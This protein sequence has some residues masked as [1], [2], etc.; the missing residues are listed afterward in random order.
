MSITYLSLS[1]K[2]RELTNNPAATAI[3][4]A[5]GGNCNT[6]YLLPG[7]KVSLA[8]A[9][10]NAEIKNIDYGSW[11]Q[12]AQ[13]NSLQADF[14]VVWLSSLAA[15]KGGTATYNL[16]Y[17]N[18]N[19][20]VQ[21]LITNKSKVLLILPEQ[22]Q[23]SRDYYAPLYKE[24]LQAKHTL[25][26]TLPSEVLFI[27]PEVIHTEL[28]S[29][30]WYAAR[31]WGLSKLPFHPNAVA[32]LSCYTANIIAKCIKPSVKAIVVDL[33]NTLWGGVVGE[34]GVDNLLLDVNAEGHPYIQ[35]QFLLKHLSQQGIPLCVVSKNN[36]EDAQAP[37]LQRDEMLLKLE[38]F[39][40]FVANWE[41]KSKN[42]GDIARKLKLSVDSICF[43]DDSVYERT[44]T[45][46]AL[47]TLIVP[48]MP[49]DPADRIATLI[50]SGMFVIPNLSQEDLD[51]ATYY[52]ADVKREAFANSV[53]PEAYLQALNMQ[54]TPIQID[55][56]NIQRV[57]SL[58]NRTN[59]FNLTNKRHTVQD[60]MH[61]INLPGT[62]AYCYQ[63]QDKFGDSGIIGVLIA[64]R[65]AASMHI[66]TFLM[67]C[68]V[69]NRK[70]EYA[71]Y[72][73]F[74]GWARNNN[75][76]QIS[77][78]YVKSNKNILVADLYSKFGLTII[79]ASNE[80]TKFAS[81]DFN[82]IIHPI[83]INH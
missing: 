34:D 46:C 16:D 42:I 32:N 2:L 23:I 18:I 21:H 30:N 20:I 39:V 79:A 13:Q 17:A 19:N 7:L 56:S 28:G 49:N 44:E 82:D 53:D 38:D 48:E 35:M 3:S 61:L 14:W 78:E 66:D 70:V 80:A 57:V 69:L 75:I 33:D 1:K 25:L 74:I 71:I 31:Y 58:I 6:E 4:I 64:I 52:K 29:A 63:L 54:L 60:V 43:I 26:Q 55:P 37:F 5:V 51:R 72:Q 73:H 12:T 62:Y 47:P 24:Y 68:R 9:G 50:N 15:T 45:K 27:D 41:A 83:T 59:Q 10:I 76:N 40:Y 77:A 11:I 36:L 8:E 81:T 65:D 67:S 22:M